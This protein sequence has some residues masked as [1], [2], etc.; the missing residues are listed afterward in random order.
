MIFVLYI[1]VKALNRARLEANVRVYGE[2]NHK[3]KWPSPYTLASGSLLLL[4]FLKYFYSP[5]QWLAI[6]A[7]LVGI[8][9]ILFKGFASIRNLTLD[10]NIL[11]L[12][13]GMYD[14]TVITSFDS[15][16]DFNMLRRS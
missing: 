7:I 4:S 1:A 11:A 15:L 5:L 10:I 8:P 6:G 9:P 14:R 12:I 13:T 3:D 2:I 16:F